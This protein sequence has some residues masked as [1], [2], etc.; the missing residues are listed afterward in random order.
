MSSF[1]CRVIWRR[2]FCFLL[3]HMRLSFDPSGKL[4]M[5]RQVIC[6]AAGVYVKRATVARNLEARKVSK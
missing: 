4:S 1:L 6:A 5:L 2:V 3:S